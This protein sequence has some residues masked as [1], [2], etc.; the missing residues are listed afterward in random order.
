MMPLELMVED[1]LESPT[2]VMAFAVVLLEIM[3]VVDPSPLAF[4]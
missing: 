1:P 3:L 2:K 4:K